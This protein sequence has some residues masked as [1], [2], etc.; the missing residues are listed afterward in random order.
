M[1]EVLTGSGLAA[2]AG[3]NA[4]IPLLVMGLLA[5]YTDVIQLPNGWQWLG[6]G[7]VVAILVVLLVVEF[8]ADKVPVVD[9]VNDVVQT[10][11]RPTAGGLAFGAG[12]GSETVTVADP[13]SFF[14]GNEWVPVV[15]GVLIALG[16]HLL[17]SAARPLINATTAG[18][19]AP[20][21]STAEDATSVL[22][23]LVAILL[24]VLVLLFL[25]G[26]VFFAFWFVRRRALRRRE[27]RAVRAGGAGR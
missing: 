13:E 20:V 17:K 26:L 4:Y 9:H 7:W 19:G 22:V 10:V 6:N 23:S 25:V 1:L 2:S 15:V 16:V 5:R 18:V 11:V 12:A 3:L 27:R 8:V 24:P 14:A 21:A